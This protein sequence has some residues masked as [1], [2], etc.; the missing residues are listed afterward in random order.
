MRESCT[1][2]RYHMDGRANRSG[3]L[4]RRQDAVGRLRRGHRETCEA[5]L[6]GGAGGGHGGRER[7]SVSLLEVP[8]CQDGILQDGVR[9]EP[10]APTGEDVRKVLRSR[11]GVK[12]GVEEGQRSS[13][14]LF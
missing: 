2:G 3:M 8:H 14:R 9:R 6:H 11:V 7:N 1:L 12:T 13:E 10:S 4:G 5:V